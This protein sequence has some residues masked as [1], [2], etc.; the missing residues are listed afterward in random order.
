MATAPSPGRQ[1]VRFGACE[2]DLRAGDLLSNLSASG[3]PTA[4]W[5]SFSNIRVGSSHGRTCH[6]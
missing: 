2:A 5:P 1:V 4:R 3:Y 6:R